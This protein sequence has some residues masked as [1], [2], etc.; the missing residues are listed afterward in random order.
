MPHPMRIEVKP[1]AG[2][3]YDR[4][5]RPKYDLVILDEQGGEVFHELFRIVDKQLINTRDLQLFMATTR[6]D[7]E[8]KDCL[9]YAICVD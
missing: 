2:L 6:V 8:V 4:N 3:I 1:G 7:T 9:F 5:N